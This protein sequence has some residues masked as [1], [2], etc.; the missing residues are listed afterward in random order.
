MK[1]LISN[2][3]GWGARGLDVLISAMRQ[4]GEVL[5]VAPE[6]GRSGQSSAITV[7]TP[8]RLRQVVDEPGLQV[9]TCSGTPADC[10]KIGMQVIM[11][12]AKPDLVCSGINHGDNSTVNARYSG[13][14]GVVFVGAEH[15]VPSIGWSLCD[16]SADADFSF[17]EAYIVGLTKR[18]LALPYTDRLCWNINAPVGQ[19]KG[20]KLTRQC[21][22]YWDKEFMPYNDPNGTPFYMLT[23]QFINTE[24]EAEDT[25]QYVLNNG[26]VS[27]CPTTIDLTF[28]LSKQPVLDL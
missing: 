24:P 9:Y 12:G 15:G 4:M 26:Y 17:L 25:D 21:R 10:A 7:Q 8:I 13:T 23:G 16:H 11:N 1:I 5:V 18:I 19:L 2:D 27:V 22:G 28:N 3:D 6:S 20:V 14:M